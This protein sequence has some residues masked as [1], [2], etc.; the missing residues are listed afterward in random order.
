MLEIGNV[1]LIHNENV[2]SGSRKSHH[3]TSINT[4]LDDFITILIDFQ[5]KQRERTNNEA[6][7]ALE[8]YPLFNDG[9]TCG[10]CHSH[11]TKLYLLNARGARG[12]AF[13]H[14]L[15]LSHSTKLKSTIHCLVK[16]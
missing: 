4:P 5:G 10:E 15:N 9:Y 7:G 12:D 2:S 1:W 8:H 13:A 11:V 3:Y 16:G 14:A 6:Q